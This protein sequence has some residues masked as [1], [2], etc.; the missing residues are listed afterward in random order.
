MGLSGWGVWCVFRGTGGRWQQAT[1]NSSRQPPSLHI[2]AT[3]RCC[4]VRSHA[5]AC[6]RKRSQ[7]C[8]CVRKRSQACACARDACGLTAADAEARI[9]VFWLELFPKVVGVE[10]GPGTGPST[11]TSLERPGTITPSTTSTPNTF[12]N[13]LEPLDIN[14]EGQASRHGREVVQRRHRER[15]REVDNDSQHKQ[16]AK[17][18]AER[19][20]RDSS[21]HTSGWVYQHGRRCRCAGAA[22]G[23][24][25]RGR[26]RWEPGAAP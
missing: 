6:A 13:S 2:V 3:K 7:T 11:V 10:G 15:S 1:E 17:H 12:M 5:C 22:G 25:Q 8:A 4:R 24:G 20:A 9:A 14:A 21:S 18:N 19:S 16:F 26:G 23:R